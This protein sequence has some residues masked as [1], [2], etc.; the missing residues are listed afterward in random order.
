MRLKPNYRLLFFVGLFIF[1]LIGAMCAR[2]ALASHHK[3]QIAFAS[4]RD[5][6]LE[7]YVMDADGNNQI[8]LTNHPEAD[9]QPSWSPDGGRI[10]FVSDRNGGNDQIYVMDSNGKNV[11]KL[12]NG[13]FDRH[14]AWSPDGKRIAYHG[15]ENE[16]WVDEDEEVNFKIYLIAPD[17]SN[18]RKLAGDIPSSNTEPAWSPDSQRI[19]FVSW[20]EDWTWTGDIGVMNAD[21][22]N[23]KR[24]THTEVNERH[25]T[26]SPDGSRIA[27]TTVLE[28][29]FVLSVMDADGTN[30]RILTEEVLDGRTQLIFHPAWSP[31]GRTIAYHF[32]EGGLDPRGIHLITADGDHLKRLG[33][34]HKGGDSWPDWF[35][36]ASL[37][38]FPASKQLT[39]WGK[40]KKLAAKLR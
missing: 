38:V 15:Y 21:G 25:P 39:I 32:A 24:L 19:A 22:T 37:A 5:G 3:A 9:F 4:T 6:N 8:R 29:D 1:L 10:A 36:P 34:M 26:W 27:F 16:E 40:L 33:D 35:D 7:I 2:T 31:D 23:Q 12:T 30:Q 11:K 18:W 14:P 17:G 20:R 13:A 28:E